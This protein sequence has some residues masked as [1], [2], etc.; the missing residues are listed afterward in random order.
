MVISIFPYPDINIIL[1]KLL[2]NVQAVLGTRLVG[3]YI[4]G[5]L[6]YGD[7][8]PQTSDIDFLVVTD[9]HISGET[10]SA[11]KD[12]HTRLFASGPAW[13]QK[14]E[15]AYIPKDDLRRHDPAHTPV[16]WLGVDGHFAL[17]TL[18]SDWVIQRWILR[19][20]GIAVAGPP[21][22]AMMDPLGA[23]DL[24]E[25][26]RVSLREWWSPPFPSPERFQSDEYQAYA[27]LTMCRSLYLLEN[28]MVA[29]KPAA[30]R[31]A[32]FALGD[33]WIG[34]IEEAA[35]WREGLEFDRLDEPV[36]LICYTLE[37]CLKLKTYKFYDELK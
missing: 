24:R 8:N 20:K 18:V 29:S 12:M 37:R 17:E 13:S 16:P 14:P 35:R 22:K 11:L 32:Q 15:G 1:G 7:F 30:A 9:D 10:F 33:R 3:L 21:L 6:A 19:E 2:T 36:G 27:V 34:L 26:V 5:S 28:G 23:D 31:W 4:H 25:A